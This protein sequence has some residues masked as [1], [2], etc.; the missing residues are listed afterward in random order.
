MVR[1]KH[2][3]TEHERMKAEERAKEAKEKRL[4]IRAKLNNM[5][6]LYLYG[7]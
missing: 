5:H 2:D 6:P 4:R 7:N 1:T 3:R